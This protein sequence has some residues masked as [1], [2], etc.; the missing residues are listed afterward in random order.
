MRHPFLLS[1]ADRI[2]P[3]IMTYSGD[4]LISIDKVAPDVVKCDGR[5]L[6]DDVILNDVSRIG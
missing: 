2:D 3:E 5:H 1:E 4:Y 6:K